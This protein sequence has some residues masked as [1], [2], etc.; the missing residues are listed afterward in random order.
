VNFGHLEPL[1][2]EQDAPQSPAGSAAH[3]RV[4]TEV[5]RLA[6]ENRLPEPASTEFICWLHREFYRE[7]PKEMLRVEGQGQEFVM[8]PGEWRSLPEHDVAVGR[9]IPPS[10][11]RVSDFIAHFENQYRLAPLGMAGR[12]M[13]MAATH[14]RFNYIHPFPDGNGRVGRLM[15]YAMAHDQSRLCPAFSTLKRSLED[16]ASW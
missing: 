12:I 4:Q 15:S 13:A 9:H 3:V 16:C 5:D 10:S 1:I 2:R 14:H 11:V 8:K 6:A 7:V